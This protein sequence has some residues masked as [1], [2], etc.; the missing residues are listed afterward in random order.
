MNL[1]IDFEITIKLD[2]QTNNRVQEIEYLGTIYN[3][4]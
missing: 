2:S 4:T 3:Y 1:A